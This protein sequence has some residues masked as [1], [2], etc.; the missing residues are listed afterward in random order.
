[1]D[2]FEYDDDM[3]NALIVGIYL[4]SINLAALP[5]NLYVQ[6]AK[7]LNKA[8]T[9]G[10]KLDIEFGKP[11]KALLKELRTNIYVFSAAKTATQVADMQSIIK[12][13]TTLADFK[14]AARAKFDI[15][16]TSSK[17]DGYLDTEY[18]TAHTSA[19][20]AANYKYTLKNK[21][22]FPR[23]RSVAIIDQYTAPECYRMNGVVADVQDPIWNHNLAPRHWRC[24]CHEERI[25][26]YDNARSTGG[27]K[28]KGIMAENDKDMQA[29]FKFNPA[30][31]KIIFSNKHPYYAIGKL[32]HKLAKQ[33]W[34][35]PIPK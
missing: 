19:S 28:L 17:H 7:V 6:T 32:H 12:K 35:L 31:E 3:I 11:D 33:N 10:Y 1:M 20:T 21:D 4:G 15:Y 5:V 26:K 22:I 13:D 8:V 29:I 27:N 14:K 24:R 16:N 2:E 34:D 18:I 9:D 30:L 23:L 25:D